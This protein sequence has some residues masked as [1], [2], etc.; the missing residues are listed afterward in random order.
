MSNSPEFQ[1][2]YNFWYEFDILG[3][4]NWDISENKVK[5]FFY[6]NDE[7]VEVEVMPYKLNKTITATPALLQHGW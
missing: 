5:M 6:Y 3:S 1:L 2:C 4:M 7:N